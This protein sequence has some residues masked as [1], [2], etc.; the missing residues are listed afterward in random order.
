MCC[1]IFGGLSN[2][3]SRVDVHDMNSESPGSLPSALEQLPSIRQ[4]LLGRDAA[5]FLDYD[6][7]LTPIVARPELARISEE[8]GGVVQELAWRCPTAIVSGRSVEALR[9][10]VRLENVY[11]AGSHGLDIVG[12]ATS[13]LRR[14]MGRDFRQTI[15]GAYAALSEAV[16]GIEGALVEHSTYAVSVHYRL[17]AQGEVPLVEA[18]VDRTLRGFLTLRNTRGKM[19]HEVRPRLDWDKGKAVLWLIEALGLDTPQTLPIYLGDNTTDEDAFRALRG[20]GLGILVA[21]VSR[22]TAAVYSLRDTHE[23]RE[24]LERLTSWVKA[25]PS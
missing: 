22:E 25:S 17:V 6:G 8:M 4:Q 5:L 11:Y 14:D 13:G 2:S 15:D 12:P 10:S 9:G 7:T 3:I 23:V 16:E 21:E 1:A 19:V 20:R 24:F 18:A